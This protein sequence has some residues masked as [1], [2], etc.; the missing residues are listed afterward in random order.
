MIEKVI[1]WTLM[2]LQLERAALAAGRRDIQRS[3]AS[4]SKVYVIKDIITY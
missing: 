3:L 2:T 4:I 1:V